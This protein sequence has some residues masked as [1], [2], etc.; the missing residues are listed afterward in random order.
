MCAFTK[1]EFLSHPAEDEKHSLINHL[2]E[3]AKKTEEILNQTNF[4]IQKV[5]FY[6]GLLHDIGKLNP[7]YQEIFLEKNQRKDEEQILSQYVRMHSPFSAWAASK[8]LDKDAGVDYHT[9]DKILSVIYGHHS[10]LYNTLPDL[11]KTKQFVSSQSGMSDNLSKF[12]CEINGIDEFSKLNWEKCLKRFSEPIKFQVKLKSNEENAVRDFLETSVLFSAL[13]QADQGSF[14]D[15]ATPHFDMEIDT[16]GLVKTQS[17]L[18]KLRSSFQQ[19]ALEHHDLETGISIL[20]APTGIGKTKVFLD[21]ISKYVQNQELERVFYFSP[22]LALTEDFENK[23]E[24]TIKEKDD[25][26]IYNHLFA[27]SL[28]EKTQQE[29][30]TYG[31]YHWLFEYES[32]NRKFIITTTQR[33]LM[34][35]YSNNSSDKLKLASFKNSLLIIDEVQTIPKFLLPNLIQI[36]SQL[37]R[38]LKTKILLVSATIPHELKSLNKIKIPANIITDYLEVIQKEISFIGQ[39]DVPNFEKQKLLIMANTRRKTVGIFTRVTRRYHNDLNKIFYLS[40][41]IRKKDRKQIIK[42]LAKDEACILVSTQVVEAGVDISFSEIYRE[43]APLD[44]IVQVMGRLNREGKDKN[45]RLSVFQEDCDWKPYSELEYYQSLD[46]LKQVNNSSE[47]YLRLPQYYQTVSSQNQ[48]NKENV[49]EISSHMSRMD[50]ERIWEF[51]YNHVLSE[52]SQENV[53][54]PENEEQWNQVKQGFTKSEKIDKSTLK[55]FVELTA[56]LPRSPA[57]LGIKDY[58]DEDLQSHNILLPKLEFLQQV[59][60]KK[61]GLDI[62]LKEK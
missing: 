37:T 60:D 18:G 57:K 44:S 53:F 14:R 1:S 2:I 49:Q 27:G 41:G 25:I 35:L 10:K 26:L 47:L 54:V 11:D 45:A 21:L 50:F 38:Y 15:W 42:Q 30:G 24:S 40:S 46:I 31:G 32:F 23:L 61:L 33:L 51:V 58:F 55:K 8:L 3:V 52:D 29:K 22:L 39:M 16:S 59:Y 12:H 5:G 43:V 48:K 9:Q 4:D 36:L 34:T 17:S 7:Y 62:W 28:T 13:L 56:S 20:H 19:A 6:A